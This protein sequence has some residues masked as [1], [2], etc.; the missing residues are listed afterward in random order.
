MLE[1]ILQLGQHMLYIVLRIKT[2]KET[3]LKPMTN[4]IYSFVE[5]IYRDMFYVFFDSM[6]QDGQ[7][8]PN[9][10]NNRCPEKGALLIF[11]DLVEIEE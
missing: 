2:C 1:N 10:N 7:F 11:E 6:T 9:Q 5:D 3:N 4:A 8:V